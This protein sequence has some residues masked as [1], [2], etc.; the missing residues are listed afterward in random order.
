MISARRTSPAR[1]LL[2]LSLRAGFM[3]NS[4]KRLEQLIAAID[5]VN[6]LDP[7]TI[8]VSGETR[9]I[10]VV[11]SQRITDTLLRMVPAPSECLRIAVRGQ[12]IE[13]WKIP[14][15][16]YPLGR[17]GYLQWRRHQREN[18]AKRL[19]EL[20]VVADYAP[21]D[22][23]R[24]GVLVRKE[25]MKTD[26]EVQTFEDVIC[27]TFLEHYLPDF[28]STVNEDKLAGIL[29]KTWNR[30]SELGHRHAL[31]LDLP[32][33]VPQLLERGLAQQNAKA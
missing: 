16:T 29:A 26:A 11:Y 1:F 3:A 9:P 5:S 4:A 33:A 13:R 32:P 18:Q 31:L 19:G 27:V 22:I 12:H 24:V 21:E 20:M 2:T 25:N 23:A 28:S 6:A 15:A 14:R 30:M 10:E 7:R 8:V 17:A